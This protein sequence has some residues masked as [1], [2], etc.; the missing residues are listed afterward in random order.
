MIDNNISDKT[1][2]FFLENSDH[3]QKLFLCAERRV[4][5]RK[6]ILRHIAHLLSAS[7]ASAVRNPDKVE[8]LAE[9]I[10]L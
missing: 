10:D 5:V 6:P 2:A 7:T 3:I 4:V 1:Y 8:I 9:L